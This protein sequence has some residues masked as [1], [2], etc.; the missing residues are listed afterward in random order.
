MAKRLLLNLLLLLLL[1]AGLWLALG[2]DPKTAAATPLGTAAKDVRELRVVGPERA[3]HLRRDERGDWRL[4]GPRALDASDRQVQTV[5]RFLDAPGQVYA[6]GELDPAAVGLDAPR[7]RLVVD[8]RLLEFGDTEAIS[9][10]RYVADSER[11]YLVLDG[12]A[13]M[14]LA[15]WWNF[16]DRRLLEP[17]AQLAAVSVDG[18]P[19]AATVLAL[20][21]Q[22]LAAKVTPA[23]A[24]AAAGPNVELLLASG[25]RRRLRLRRAAPSGLVDPQRDL[26]YHLDSGR[27]DRLVPAQ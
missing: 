2:G 19:L 18:R 14:L 16:I 4:L 17:D 9:G 10:R 11:V 27:L 12:A 24:E 1:G 25:E 21:Q 5:L 26:L 20:W 7:L 6:R 22:L 15:P 23:P 13:P 8:G 3:L